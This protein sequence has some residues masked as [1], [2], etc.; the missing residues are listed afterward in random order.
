MV[1]ISKQDI[2]NYSKGLAVILLI[3]VIWEVAALVIQNNYIL[4]TL[5]AIFAVLLHPFAPVLG[6][7][8][9]IDNML[10]SLKEVLLGFFC[11]AAFAIPIGLLVGWSTEARAYFNPVI[12]ILRPV[13][14]IAWM[15]FAIAWFGIGIH[16][17]VFII[18]MGAFFPILINTVDG[19]QGVRRRWTEVAMMLHATQFEQ[20]RTVVV[21]GALPVIWTGLRVSFGVAWMCV[22][23][24]EMLPGTSAGLGFLI[25]YAYNLGQLQVIGAGMII[26]GLIGLCADTIFRAGRSRFFS[27]QGRE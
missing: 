16:S 3:L 1:L 18:I 9:L 25:M 7:E 20:V 26:I 24:A 27:W 10:V 4:P 13:P 12:Q 23:A 2:L 6:G 11:A 5:G 19:V 21:P 15:P 8:S 22:V 17:V 14:P